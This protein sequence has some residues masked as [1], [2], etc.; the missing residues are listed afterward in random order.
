M[1]KQP[2][3][4]KDTVKTYLKND[5]IRNYRPQIV[6][7][8]KGTDKIARVSFAQLIL[9]RVSLSPNFLERIMFSDEAVFQL[10]G[11]INTRNCSHWSRTNPHWTIEKSLN[12]PKVMVWAAFGVSG[13]L[14]FFHQGKRQWWKVLQFVEWGV[15]PS[16]PQ[17]P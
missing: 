14:T 17:P 8:L 12:S 6:Q 3:I 10:D 13:L 4:S 16:F 15:L 11:G 1:G 2:G 7:A 5:G 9:Y